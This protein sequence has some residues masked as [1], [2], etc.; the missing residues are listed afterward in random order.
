MQG[1]LLTKNTF[2]PKYISKELKIHHQ[3]TE[4]IAKK[5]NMSMLDLNI[6]FIKQL[7]FLDSVI[8]GVTNLE[9]LNQFF[10]SWDKKNINLNEVNFKN[11]SWGNLKDIDPRYWR[12][13]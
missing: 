1:L 4:S 3:K 2:W 9:E 7:S 5:M 10:T 12:K 8:I 6:A 13:K 11:L